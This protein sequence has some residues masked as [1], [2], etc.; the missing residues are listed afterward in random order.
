MDIALHRGQHDGGLLRAGLLLHLGLEIGDRLLHHSGGIEHRRQLHLAR[1]KQIAHR[2]HAVEQH[3]VDQVERRILGQSFFQ[4]F[5]QGL[6]VRALADRF[7]AVDD[8]KLQLVLD[9]QRF[10]MRRGLGLPFAFLAG[11]VVHVFLQ[12]VAVRRCIAVNQL[13]RKINFFL[14]NLV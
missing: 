6:L 11:E 4:H 12:R 10:D 7:F 9:R 3:G 1:A 8:G 14:R 5:F 13:E 2:A